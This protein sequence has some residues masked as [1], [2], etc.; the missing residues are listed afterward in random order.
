MEGS[1][2]I[3]SGA[4][5]DGDG[6]VA[7]DEWSEALGSDFGAMDTNT[8]GYVDMDERK[9]A[10]MKAFDAA[11]KAEKCAKSGEECP[12]ADEEKEKAARAA[13]AVSAVPEEEC[14]LEEEAPKDPLDVLV[15]IR[16]LREKAAKAKIM[17]PSMR[18]N[19]LQMAETAA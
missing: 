1:K 3:V 5:A 8:D 9:A 4:D 13:E 6:K 18:K 17:N 16:V 19:V 12:V 7:L 11:L 2:G 14:E 15:D 10:F